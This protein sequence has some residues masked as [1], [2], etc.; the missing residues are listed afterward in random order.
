MIPEFM[1]FYNYT[2][3]DV[4]DEYARTFFSLVNSMLEISAK[5]LLNNIMVIKTAESKDGSKIIEQL[6]KQQRGLGAIIKEVKVVKGVKN[7]S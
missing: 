4:L 7:V 1:R 3:S 6:Y 5:E 2:A